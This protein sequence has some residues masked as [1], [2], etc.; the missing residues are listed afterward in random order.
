[1][2][3]SGAWSEALVAGVVRS[4]TPGAAWVVARAD[5]VYG[6][7]C[8]GR[9]SCGGPGEHTGRARARRGVVET[10]SALTTAN[11][12]SA[13]A[14]PLTVCAC[15]SG[16]HVSGCPIPYGPGASHA[17]AR[18]A[19]VGGLCFPCVDGRVR[20]RCSRHRAWSAPPLTPGPECRCDSRPGL[21]SGTDELAR[22]RAVQQSDHRSGCDT[23]C[24]DHSN[25]DPARARH[26]S[27]SRV[28]PVHVRP[29]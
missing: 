17:G 20:Q 24:G 19:A 2:G 1:M 4:R 8:C 28:T 7:G 27:P 21:H 3:W 11:T 5:G 9:G 16:A 23:K 14:A 15:V 13:S 22:T 25:G 10:S 18:R 6:I 29:A 12:I 26:I